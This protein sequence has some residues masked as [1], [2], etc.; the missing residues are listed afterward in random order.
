MPEPMLYREFHAAGIPFFPLYRFNH[1]LKCE[2]G[3]ADCLAVGKHPR[4]R[5]WQNTPLWDHDQ[6]E[7]MEE[8]GHLSSGYGI[9]CKGLLVIDVDARNGGVESLKKLCADYPDLE[10]SCGLE[11]TTGSGG[12]SRHLYYRIDPA[13][14]LVSHLAE[15]PGIDFK[16]SGYVVGPGSHH[17][18]GNVYI[19]DG[20]VDDIG[21]PPPALLEA[22]RKKEHHRAEYAGHSI[23]VT[24]ADIADMLSHIPNNDVD[25]DMWVSVG[26]AIHHATQGTGYDLWAHWSAISAKHNERIMPAKWHSF[27]KAS[28]PVTL[29]TLTH[30]A[31]KGGWVQP[32]TFVPDVEYEAPIQSPGEYPVDIGGIDLTR[33]PGFVG[34][35]AAWID[36]QS[37]R[38]RPNLAVA[39]ALVSIGNIGGLHYVDDL[40]GVTANLFAFCVA[41]SRTGKDAIL[42]AAT[43]LMRATGI[44]AAVH[45]AIKSEAEVYR[46]L[47]RHQ[48][49]FYVVDEVAEFMSR[50][51]NA[52][53]RGGASY[54]E[55]VYGTLMSIYSKAGKFLSITGDMKE[56]IR[57]ALT[58]ELS[59]LVKQMD[60]KGETP[61][62]TGKAASVRH[63]LET[64]D[65]GLER[66]FL[67]LMGVTTPETFEALMGYDMAVNGFIGRCLIFNERETVPR[68]RFAHISPPLPDSISDYLRAIYTN[69]KYDM[70]AP[71]R[72]EN[73]S[74]PFAVPTDDEGRAALQRI[75]LWLE[76]KAE[77]HKSLT[78]YE[79]L[80]LG[81]Y[82]IVSKVSLILAIPE[83][84][85]TV[86]HVAWA[87]A[88]V[89]RDIEE[90]I[91][92]VIG[93]DSEKSAPKKSLQARLLNIV[94]GEDGEK[95]GV[96]INRLQRKFR[97][98]DILAELSAMTTKGL[99]TCI[100]QEHK[101][102]KSMFRRYKKP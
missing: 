90:K 43:A 100:E 95:E 58:A 64:I 57:K 83:R 55:G 88:I 62:L 1:N 2:C 99:L 79:A 102:N 59:S 31:E 67:S 28:N 81:A 25:Y 35:V 12:G 54:L 49:A 33:P 6:I 14:A 40:S 8:Y 38:P 89:K 73:Y 74:E 97:R 86:E 30:H 24:H 70:A 32:V 63:L 26:M 41:G 22:L 84:L 17:K 11:V 85:R 101:T 78:G 16:S 7:A 60:D 36:S 10:S 71:V 29:G 39:A 52:Q 77:E 9:L 69:G 34:E 37:I 45:G 92:L 23:D 94:S 65:N 87:F 42:T 5:N 80:W 72:V 91:Q 48:A 96:I 76:D 20:Y 56:D 3:N 51:G 68:A 4:A 50:V 98:E 93:T 53:K 44:S 18:S 82:E 21:P 47:T 46:N 15:Y 19:A 27:G 75:A 66:P 13:L 61:W